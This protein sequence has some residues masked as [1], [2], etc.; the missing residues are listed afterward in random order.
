MPKC[1]SATATTIGCE[2]EQQLDGTLIYGD[3][4]SVEDGFCTT[5]E[6]KFSIKRCNEGEAAPN[7]SQLVIN[8][9]TW[10]VVSVDSCSGKCWQ[11][12]TYTL[13]RVAIPCAVDLDLCHCEEIEE[14]CD[15]RFR[16]KF[17]EKIQGRVRCLGGGE[18]IRDNHRYTGVRYRLYSP[19]LYKLCDA[20]PKCRRLLV[21]DGE[22]SYR[23]VN[24]SLEGDCPHA[25]LEEIKGLEPDE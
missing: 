24:Y 3:T 25:T 5:Q 2:E 1:E 13:K 8:G 4:S 9:V 21:K 20:D 7:A 6:A 23:I 19:E 15:Y 14:D 16:S 10:Q 22:K 17:I 18:V 11:L 12:I